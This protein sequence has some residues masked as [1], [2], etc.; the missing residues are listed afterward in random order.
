MR[1]PRVGDRIYYPAALASREQLND[2]DAGQTLITVDAVFATR[3]A[4]ERICGRPCPASDDVPAPIVIGHPD[5]VPDATYHCFATP[6]DHAFSWR[7]PKNR[8]ILAE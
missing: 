2:P 3:E 5:D 7:N 4:Y 1:T 6:G 8:E